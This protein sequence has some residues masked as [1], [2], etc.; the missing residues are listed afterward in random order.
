[1]IN[2]NYL[3]HLPGTGEI[4]NLYNQLI[5][6]SEKIFN[7]SEELNKLKTELSVKKAK[8]ITDGL[9]EGTNQKARDASLAVLTADDESAI[10]RI[11]ETLRQ[12]QFA[13]DQLKLQE[14]QYNMLLRLAEIPRVEFQ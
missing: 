5:A 14:R 12:H 2:K 10:N 6:V 7:T 1:M 4:S 3:T 11:D 13:Y 9:V 8:L